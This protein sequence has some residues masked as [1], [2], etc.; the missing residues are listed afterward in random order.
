MDMVTNLEE[1]KAGNFDGG[2]VGNCCLSEE[3]KVRLCGI[4][5]DVKADLHQNNPPALVRREWPWRMRKFSS[6]LGLSGSVPA[7]GMIILE[8]YGR[9]HTLVEGR[10]R[11]DQRVPKTGN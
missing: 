3:E 2:T 11:M 9:R 4:V 6:M 8:Q 10:N 1:T 7:G 5:T